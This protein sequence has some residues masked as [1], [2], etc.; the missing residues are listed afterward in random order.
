MA[1]VEMVLEDYGLKMK[2]TEKSL[3]LSDLLGAEDDVLIEDDDTS[4]DEIEE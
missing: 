2:Q 3:Y 4:W 1:V